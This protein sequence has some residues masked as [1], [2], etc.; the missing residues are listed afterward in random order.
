MLAKKQFGQNFL[1]NFELAKRMAK[2]SN[3]GPKSIVLEIG[4]GKGVLTN[5]LLETKS[6]VIA[7]EKDHELI[8]YLT[9]RFAR[10]IKNKKLVLIKDDIRDID[11]SRLGL[12]VKN[13]KLVANI[14][15]Y[16]TGE[17]MRKFLENKNQPT[18]MVLMIQKEVA[19]RILA[20]DKRESLLSISVKAYGKPELETYV[21]R[22]SF[23]PIPKVDSAILSITQIN[24]KFFKDFSEQ[25]FFKILK[26]GF[27]HKRKFL[28][29]NLS[30]IIKKDELTQIFNKMALPKDI[31]AE[32]MSFIDWKKLVS[33]LT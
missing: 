16:L 21:K 4:P 10:E 33:D 20:H 24:K 23:N 6:K 13:Y 5:A 26:A 32:K 2:I 31:W 29:S 25:A 8:P 7:I 17:I 12:K 22:G 18:Q 28:F 19:Q 14:P 9:E 27:I 30:K 11:L 15:Y 3:L 1:I